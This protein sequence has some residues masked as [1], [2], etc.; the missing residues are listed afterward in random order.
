MT[1]RRKPRPLSAIGCVSTLLWA[2]ACATGVS[3]TRGSGA[4]GGS[5]GP[6]TTVGAGA[7]SPSQSSPPVPQQCT[8]GVRRLTIDRAQP[9]TP[10]C[11]RV[12]ATLMIEAPASPLQ[13]W[14][15]FHTS[16]PAL[17]SCDT[18]QSSDGAATTTCHARRQGNATLST[19]TAAFSGDP[20]GPAQQLWLL[21][22]TVQP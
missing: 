10:I 19:S 18:Q 3:A 12:G 22:V 17:L 15:A 21:A 13:P 5:A 8:P 4:A 11:V 6:A 20:H 2:S 14:Q 16:N 9:P 7:T 1:S